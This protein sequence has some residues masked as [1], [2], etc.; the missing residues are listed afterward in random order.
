MFL[1]V[2]TLLLAA[3]TTLLGLLCMVCFFADPKGPLDWTIFSIRDIIPG[4]PV[5]RDI[6]AVC[7]A[8]SYFSAIEYCGIE[9]GLMYWHHSAFVTILFT[10]FV[11]C[12]IEKNS[13]SESGARMLKSAR[14]WS[15]VVFGLRYGLLAALCGFAP[16]INAVVIMRF[17]KQYLPVRVSTKVTAEE[18]ECFIR[19]FGVGTLVAVAGLC[20]VLDYAS[21]DQAVS[22]SGFF[23]DYL[24]ATVILVYINGLVFLLD[25]AGQ[26]FGESNFH[27]GTRMFMQAHQTSGAT[28]P[29]LQPSPIGCAVFVGCSFLMLC[30]AIV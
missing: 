22:W 14:A 20:S 25:V 29:N 15:V 28:L 12:I 18:S 30:I 5:L 4:Q 2:D 7:M 26:K 16:S 10:S 3:I 23:L 24:F 27:V 17:I 9:Q 21:I 13:P 8:M 19:H 11:S 1:I 6:A